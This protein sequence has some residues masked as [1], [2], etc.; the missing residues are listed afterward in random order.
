MMPD[1]MSRNEE[2]PPDIKDKESIVGGLSVGVKA[3]GQDPVAQMMDTKI[4][5]WVSR[6][7]KRATGCR[8]IERP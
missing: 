6:N 4:H 8:I 3:E 1:G 7:E 2:G 5:C